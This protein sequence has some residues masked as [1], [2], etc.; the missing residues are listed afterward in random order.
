MPGN[1]TDPIPAL[2]RL[3]SWRERGHGIN[4]ET[5]NVTKGN[6]RV[7]AK[8]GTGGP[9]SLGSTQIGVSF[10][11]DVAVPVGTEGWAETWQVCR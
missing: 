6:G 2:R 10:S 4:D 9:R 5:V 8:Q 3:V 7:L 1:Q 11:N